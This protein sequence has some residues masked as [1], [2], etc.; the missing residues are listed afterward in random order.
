MDAGAPRS[1]PG[2]EPGW[3]TVA[4]VRRPHGV[5]GELH[6]ALETDRPDAVFRKG[7]TLELGDAKGKPVGRRFTISR[8]RPFKDGILLTVEELT[9]RDSEVEGLRGMSFLIPVTEAA[10][11]AEGEVF[12]RDLLGCEVV[13]AGERIGR[14]KE[15]LPTRGSELLVIG[16]RGARD[17]LVPFVAEMVKKIDVER[18]TVEID[19]PEGLLDL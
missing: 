9:S 2:G 18:R 17:L 16:R 6:L 10:P 12:Y 5:R 7:R 11:P 19:P 3:L 14:V 1:A 13:V 4:T 15:L 8:V